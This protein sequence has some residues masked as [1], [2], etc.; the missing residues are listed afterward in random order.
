MQDGREKGGCGMNFKNHDWIMHERETCRELYDRQMAKQEDYDLRIRRAQHDM[1]S[2]MIALLGMVQAK[3]TEGAAAYIHSL[4]DENVEYCREEA[5][6]CGNVVIDSL[7][8]YGA[9]LAKRE[10]ILFDVDMNLPSDLPFQNR[11]LAA[12]FG[13]LL[14]NALEACCQIKDKERYIKVEASYVKEILMI[15]VRN[16]C[17]GK[18]EREQD[19]RFGTTKRDARNHG[20]GLLSVEQAA[21]FY[22]GQMETKYENGIFQ[23]V[24]LMYGSETEK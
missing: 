16:S 6:H 22:H 13:N 9:V 8:N 18:R 17:E 4:L 24:V 20:L 1:K 10:G 23:A 14:E 12:V 2:H 21:E 5:A 11:H 19:G 3:D 7:M 15:T